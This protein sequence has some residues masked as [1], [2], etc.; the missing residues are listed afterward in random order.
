M[1]P[2]ATDRHNKMSY[3]H[4][5]KI[6]RPPRSFHCSA[7]GFC[8]EVHDHHCP[9]VGTCIGHRNVR[10]FI[11]FLFW[12]A[13]HALLVF[14]VCLYAF[15]ATGTTVIDDDFQGVVTKGVLVYTGVISLSLFCFGA[16]QLFCLGLDNTASNEDIRRR[17]NGHNANRDAVA[18]FKEEAP[19]NAKLSQYLCS[20]LPESKLHK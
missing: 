18:I 19:L 1:K 7:C 3:C 15:L 10:H 6:L 13:F 4:S 12:T 17:W 14:L 5:C 11:G 8:V 9:W 2:P 20:E 16:Y